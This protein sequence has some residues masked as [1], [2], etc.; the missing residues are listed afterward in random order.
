[1]AEQASTTA[2]AASDHSSFDKETSAKQDDNTSL[3]K[4][5]ALKHPDNTSLDKETGVK[6]D[7]NLEP[8]RTISRVPGNTHYYEKDGLRT[9]G[10]DEDHDHEPPVSSSSPFAYLALICTLVVLPPTHVT[11]SNGISLDWVTDSC[12][13]IW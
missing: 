5:I 7:E 8:I 13:L 3:D 2:P 10:D 1:M 11:Y 12:V 6:L 4:Q 9:Y